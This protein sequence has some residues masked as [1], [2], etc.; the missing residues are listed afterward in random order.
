[1]QTAA[2]FNEKISDQKHE[3]I[4]SI[5]ST[6]RPHSQGSEVL[7]SILMGRGGA[8]GQAGDE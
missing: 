4:M 2:F 5:S 8:L 7:S 6:N 3:E 1:M